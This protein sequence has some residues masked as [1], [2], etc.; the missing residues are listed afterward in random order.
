M[1]IKLFCC[2]FEDVDEAFA[3]SAWGKKL[4]KRSDK[5][6]TTDFDR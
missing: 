4:K 1:F 6:N 2:P 3:E 5:A